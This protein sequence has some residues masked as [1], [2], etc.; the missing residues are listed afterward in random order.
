M[1]TASLSVI[2]PIYNVGRYLAPCLDSIIASTLTDIKI[3]CVDDGST[4]GSGAVADDHADKDPRITV[5]HVENGGLGR[6][7]NIGTTQARGEYLAFVGLR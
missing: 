3:I 2:V 6:A 7:R 4:D 5:L 1:P